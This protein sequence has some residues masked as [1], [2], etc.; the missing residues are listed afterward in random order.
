MVKFSLSKKQN[1][2]NRQNNAKQNKSCNLRRRSKSKSNSQQKGG[3]GQMGHRDLEHSSIQTG[4]K[5][6]KEKQD[7]RQKKK[8]NKKVS[9]KKTSRRNRLKRRGGA[10]AAASQP[11]PKEATAAR[12]ARQS[13][14]L[15][16]LGLHDIGYETLDDLVKVEESDFIA[17][18]QEANIPEDTIKL[19]CKLREATREVQLRQE[20]AKHKADME[21]IKKGVEAEGR[22][23][24]SAE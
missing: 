4:G 14:L 8:S 24:S 1:N 7:N 18:L 16:D 3:D 11:P 19:L 13:R 20:F 6:N 21:E 17:H 5:R 2:K 15:Q 23:H 10:A 22:P 9:N 12:A